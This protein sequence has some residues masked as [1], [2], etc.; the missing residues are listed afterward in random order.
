MR[1]LLD[2]VA[3]LHHED[4]VRVFDRREAVGTDEARAVLRQCIHGPLRQKFGAGIDGGRCL[5]EDEHRRK[6]MHD[7]RDTKQ[8]LLPL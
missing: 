3:V 6:C 2:D 4:E 8:L 7:T 5:I 1:A